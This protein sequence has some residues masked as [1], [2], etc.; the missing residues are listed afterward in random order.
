M[1]MMERGVRIMEL[2]R[3][4]KRGVRIME[5]RGK[6]RSRDHRTEGTRGIKIM[7][8]REQEGSGLCD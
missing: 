4:K 3:R 8:L 5:L 6:K 7:Q 2:R 1:E